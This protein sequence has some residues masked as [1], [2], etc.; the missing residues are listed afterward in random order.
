MNM[1][2]G[3][4]ICKIPRCHGPHEAPSSGRPDGAE[5]SVVALTS[6]STREPRSRLAAHL[7]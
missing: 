6:A 1:V 3:E 5:V 2:L 4:R 7:R